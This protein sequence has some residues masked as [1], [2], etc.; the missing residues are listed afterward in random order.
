MRQ[1][2]VNR[3]LQQFRPIAQPASPASAVRA[4][5]RRQRA[6]RN[7]FRELLLRVW[8]REASSASQEI[9]SR[10]SSSCRLRPVGSD[11][12]SAAGGGGRTR[13]ARCC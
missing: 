7:N 9:T 11:G 6:R 5:V 12:S 3:N 1:S 8:G 10:A 4:Q 13:D 2:E